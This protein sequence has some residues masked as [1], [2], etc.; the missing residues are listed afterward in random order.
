[1]RS[2]R[3]LTTRLWLF[4]CFFQLDCTNK[5]VEHDCSNLG[6]ICD[7]PKKWLQR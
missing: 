4:P 5:V 2:Y 7:L 6:A 1:M 3:E